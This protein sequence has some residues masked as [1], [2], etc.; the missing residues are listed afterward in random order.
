MVPVNFRPH[1]TVTGELKDDY[2]SYEDAEI[3]ILNKVSTLA[4]L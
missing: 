3:N 1:I 4:C 2:W